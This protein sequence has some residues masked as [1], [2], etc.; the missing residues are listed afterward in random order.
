MVKTLAEEPA[1]MLIIKGVIDHLPLFSIPNQVFV[2][3]SPQ[4][5]FID[6]TYSTGAFGV[7]T[8]INT[9]P[10]PEPARVSATFDDI[11]FTV[12]EPSTFA[13]TALGLLGLLSYG[14]RR[15]LSRV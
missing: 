5:M 11:F 7:E 10:F 1:D 3:E 6:S 13:V 8:N 12:P 2:P 9:V 4:L 14:G 15:R